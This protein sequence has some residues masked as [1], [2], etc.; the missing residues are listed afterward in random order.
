MTIIIIGERYLLLTP[1]TMVGGPLFHK[2][3]IKSKQNHSLLCRMRHRHDNNKRESTGS[4]C[5]LLFY[6]APRQVIA[7]IRFIYNKLLFF[8]YYQIYCP[9]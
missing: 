3:E 6:G 2:I 7:S 8:Y 5:V 9:F 1:P 4:V